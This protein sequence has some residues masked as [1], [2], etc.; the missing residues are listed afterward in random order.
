MRG[1]MNKETREIHKGLHDHCLKEI[2]L[3]K[4]EKAVLLEA[5]EYYNGPD[6]GMEGQSIIKDRIVAMK[7]LE[8][9]KTIS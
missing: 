2:S 8:K 6:C 5:V 4:K 9:L 1:S 7:T 3:L